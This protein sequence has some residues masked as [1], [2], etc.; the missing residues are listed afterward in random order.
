LRTKLLNLAGQDGLDQFDMD[1]PSGSFTSTSSSSVTHTTTTTAFA[2]GEG[3]H[4]FTNEELTH[5]I[6]L[7]PNFQFNDDDIPISGSQ[8]QNPLYARMR[9]NFQG[10]FWACLEDELNLEP[11]FY[12]RVLK[13]VGEIREGLKVLTGEDEAGMSEII[14]IDF[15]KGRIDTGSFSLDDAVSMFMRILNIIKRIQAPKRKDET[16]A[17]WAE[18]S[19]G[20][21]AMICKCLQFFLGRINVMRTDVSNARFRMIMPTIVENGMK[22]ETDKFEDMLKAGTMTDTRVKEWLGQTLK[23][24]PVLAQQIYDGSR[25]AAVELH[26]A[27]MVSLLLT[28][29][30]LSSLPGAFEPTLFLP[31]TLRLDGL[32]LALLKSELSDLISIKAAHMMVYGVTKDVKIADSVCVT[33]AAGLMNV[34]EKFKRYVLEILKPDNGVRVLLRTRAEIFLR[35]CIVH[36]GPAVIEDLFPTTGGKMPKEFV[37]RATNLVKTLCR[38]AVLNRQ[39]HVAV[40]NRIIHSLLGIS[41]SAVV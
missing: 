13:V 25:I 33:D 18:I 30:S 29:S 1:H 22:Y 26:A 35:Q 7:N 16:N 27:A 14:D 36:H 38:V 28:S 12:A 23:S 2:S 24:F 21:S 39:V 6:L 19:T 32:R 40:Y 34:P 9:E 37:D 41:S 17:K 10:A 4:C 15:I 20:G 8:V 3:G 11:P 5:E 31:E